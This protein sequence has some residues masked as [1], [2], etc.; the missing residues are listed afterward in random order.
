MLSTKLFIE[1]SSNY[2]G[3][4]AL[5][6]SQYQLSYETLYRLVDYL[7]LQFAA[8]ASPEKT[9]CILLFNN[10]IEYVATFLAVARLCPVMPINPALPLE[11]IQE[12][13]QSLNPASVIHDPMN[14]DK[15]GELA[16]RIGIHAR[17]IRLDN[18]LVQSK[19]Q[20]KHQD[21]A[22]YPKENE[23]ALILHTSGTTAKPKCVPLSYKNLNESIANIIRT[24]QLSINDRNLN[25]MPLFH[26]HGIVASMLSTLASGGTLILKDIDYTKI[27]DYLINDKPTWYTAVPTIH[28]KIYQALSMQPNEC[29]TGSLRFVRSCSSPLSE[30][31]QQKIQALLN[32]PVIQAYG[33]TEAA[34]QVSTN[35]LSIADIKINSVGQTKG[36][37]SVMIIGDENQKLNRNEVGEV[38]IQGDNV[39]QGYMNNPEAN[40]DAFIQ[41]HFRT[42]DL[43]YIDSDGYLFLTGRKKEIINKGG[44]KIAPLQIDQ[45]MLRHPQIKEAITF[46]IPHETLGDDI[47]LMVV[48]EQG[49]EKKAIYEYLQDKVAEYML[50]Y[51]IYIVDDIPKSATGKINRLSI[52]QSLPA[53]NKPFRKPQNKLEEELV[54][55]WKSLLMV[56]QVSVDDN[57]F[58]LGGNS[59]LATEFYNYIATS[60]QLQLQPIELYQAPT[61]AKIAIRIYENKKNAESDWLSEIEQLLKEYENNEVHYGYE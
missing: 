58:Q 24:L 45:V 51:E 19:K 36:G 44:F 39:F 30:V 14:A 26:I 15:A 20:K 11:H 49:L 7:Q 61:I 37:I 27:T 53:T 50:P 4:I 2:Y 5:E 34:H 16:Q 1:N 31:L 35:P 9:P 28:H 54:E 60:H 40:K 59:L 33:M 43:G 13:V 12:V 3:L 18:A 38:C 29:A 46:P 42:G 21:V 22:A 17:E 23:V 56:P 10:N 55:L 47:G 57:F 32:V 41:G 8:I 48:T 52:A 25:M 6:S